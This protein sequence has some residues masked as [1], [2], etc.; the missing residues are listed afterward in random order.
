MKSSSRIW[1]LLMAVAAIAV[2]SVALMGCPPQEPAEQDAS[3]PE[4]PPEAIDMDDG[5]GPGD[6]GEPA[7]TGDMDGADEAEAVDVTLTEWEIDMPDRLSPGMTAFNVANEGDAVHNLEIEGQGIERELEN[8][9]QPGESATMKV[10]L[11]VGEYEVYC[12]VGDH[13]DKG[14]SMTLTVEE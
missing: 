2:M 3:P 1:F 13:A 8:D 6:T 11:Q 4:P 7:E 14:M 9:L 5:G 12:P 10:D